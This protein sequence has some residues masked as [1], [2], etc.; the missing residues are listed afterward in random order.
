MKYRT[1]TSTAK[2]LYSTHSR[3]TDVHKVFH[4]LKFDDAF[5]TVADVLYAVKTIT[6]KDILEKTARFFSVSLFGSY[7][8]FCP[9]FS[10]QCFR[11][12]TE[13]VRA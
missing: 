11:T 1:R 9:L 7:E 6:P 4:T 3:T 12:Q 8:F 13:T 10:H 2:L 5:H